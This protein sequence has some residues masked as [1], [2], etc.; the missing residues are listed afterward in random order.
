MMEEVDELA[1]L[2]RYESLLH[3]TQALSKQSDIPS[4][5]QTFASK[6]KYVSDV[7][8][9]RYIGWSVGN[10]LDATDL[11]SLVSICARGGES[12]VDE[13][14]ADGLTDFESSL[15]SRPTVQLLDGDER[16]DALCALH[17]EGLDA[18]LGQVYVC[19]QVLDSARPSV[20][21]YAARRGPFDS[22][23]LKFLALASHLFSE[24]IRHVQVERRL[25][26]ALEEKLTSAERMR[27]IE[28][29]MRTQERMASLGKLVAGVSHELNTP[30]GV[31]GASRHTV[32]TAARKV[33]AEVAAMVPEG[34]YHASKLEAVFGV[35]T[36]SVSTIGQAVERIDSLAKGLK[37]FARLDESEYQVADL[38]EGIESILTLLRSEI[39][40]RISVVRNYAGRVPLHCS[41]AQLNQALMHLIRNAVEAI[42]KD[43]EIEITTHESKD[44]VSVEIR[45][46][47]IG[48]TSE[49]LARIFDF[50]F[51]GGSRVKM[52]FGLFLAKKIVDDHGGSISIASDPGKGTTA[53]VKL[54]ISAGAPS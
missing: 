34:E 24:K 22:L 29:R 17:Q 8:S 10:A 28:G 16:R 51:T 5:A 38:H 1:R 44:E 36:D 4:S 18:D 6:L 42:P 39:E 40:G 19:P 43:G 2:A 12:L 41:P 26:T 23:D 48:M 25:R 21:L 20:V 49:N 52:G 27:R 35:L 32:Q 14:T 30:L 33:Q 11:H 45:D 46:T 47:G 37:H 9:W 54:P 13:I 7:R 50:N 53:T 3:L 15:L 31:I